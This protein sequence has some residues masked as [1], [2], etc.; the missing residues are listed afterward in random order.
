[1]SSGGPRVIDLFAG[2]GGMTRGFVAAGFVPV[3]A[4]EHDL[5][6]A[7]T[8]AV[9]FGEDHVRWADIRTL[10]ETDLIDADVVV[11]GPPCQGF[12][13]LGAQQWNDPR[14]QL[15]EEF[16]RVV[17]AVRPKVFVIENVDAFRKSV[18]YL[19]LKAE[20]AQGRLKEYEDVTQDLV[21]SADFGVPQRRSRT[22]FVASRVGRVPKLTATHSKD[23]RLFTAHWTD[24]RS[25]IGDLE[26]VATSS[27][28]PDRSVELFGQRIPGLFSSRE[29]HLGRQPTP[30]SLARFRHVPPGGGRKNLPFDL[31]PVCWQNKL[32]GTTDVMGRLTWD[33]PSVTIRTEFFKPEKGRYLHPQWHESD[34]SQSVDRPIT[35]L[36]AARLQSFPDEFLWCGSKVEI[37]RQIG[38]AVPPVLARAVAESLLCVLN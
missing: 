16:V 4:V 26:G 38:N 29:L 15:W 19:L 1:M 31:Q 30:L 18:Q 21:N 7:A 27:D 25:A 14:N 35:H 36:E 23:G 8:Y 3:L 34:L 24:V 37:A 20:I 6:A 9:N 17:L 22:M 12:S 11:G 2:C 10:E 33:R 28:L 13:R 5:A 32:S